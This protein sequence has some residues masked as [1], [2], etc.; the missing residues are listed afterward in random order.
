MIPFFSI[1]KD[2]I[3]SLNLFYYLLVLLGLIITSWIIWSRFFRER[4]IR[5]IPD[6][7]LTEIRFWILLYICFIYLYVVK[8]L[9]K[10]PKPNIYIS[11]LS[12][13]LNKYLS[14]PLVTLDHLIKHNR[15]N[16]D[17]YYKIILLL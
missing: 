17:Y 4:T 7:L 16:N 2:Y 10:E 15:Y 3:I 1:L 12:G 9:I 5:D 14:K 8:T 13:L 6:Y 11:M